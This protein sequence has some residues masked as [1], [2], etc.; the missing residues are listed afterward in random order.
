MTDSFLTY[1]IIIGRKGDVGPMFV[2]RDEHVEC[3]LNNYV[4]LPVELWDPPD[5]W[6]PAVPWHPPCAK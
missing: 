4:I 5:D 6:L 2:A 3:R 1:C